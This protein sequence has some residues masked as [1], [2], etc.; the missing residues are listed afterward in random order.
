[1]CEITTNKQRYLV[2]GQQSL[3]VA[4]H[5]SGSPEDTELIG[6]TDR[7]IAS[8]RKRH[9]SGTREKRIYGKCDCHRYYRVTDADTIV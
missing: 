7:T 3:R 1:M 5:L 2:C 8:G 9:A 4:Q 6:R